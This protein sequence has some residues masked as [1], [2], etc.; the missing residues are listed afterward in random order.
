MEIRTIEPQRPLAHLAKLGRIGVIAGATDF[1]IEQDLRRIYP[2]GIEIFTSRVRSVNPLTMENLGSMGTGIRAAADAVLPGTDLDVMMYACTSG[3]VAL[4]VTR[5]AEL[6][7]QS[8][9]GMAVTNPVSA[10]LGAFQHVGAKRIS[11]LTPYTESVNKDVAA[12]F[13]NEG[14]DVL[15]IAGF[16]F[17][18]DTAMTFIALIDIVDAAVSACHP[19]A[20][21]LYIS[22]TA[23][24]ASQVINFIEKRIGKRVVSS[25]QALVWHSLQLLQYPFSVAGFGI[26]LEGHDAL[27]QPKERAQW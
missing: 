16:G 5:I 6:I 1:N 9:P 12:L 4:G 11:I 14:Y 21:L 19:E 13:A 20:D 23:L 2:V 17:E 18:D 3:T 24:R 15:N 8:R 7:H 10:V 25:N 22:C 27:V 26:L